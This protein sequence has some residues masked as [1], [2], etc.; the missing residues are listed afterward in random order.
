MVD[1]SLDT[2]PVAPNQESPIVTDV[3]IGV[4]AI[5]GLLPSAS[6]PLD[7]L[8]PQA[9][10]SVVTDSAL[11][12]PVNG[13]NAG[14][15]KTSGIFQSAALPTDNFEPQ[16]PESAI[17]NVVNGEVIINGVDVDAVRVSGVFPSAVLPEDNFEPQAP[18]SVLNDEFSRH[19]ETAEGEDS[20]ASGDFP[21]SGIVIATPFTT[22]EPSTTAFQ[23]K[24]RR[25]I[26]FSVGND[27]I[28][29]NETAASI[30]NSI[31]KS[32]GITLGTAAGL[33][34]VVVIAFGVALRRKH[35]SSTLRGGSSRQLLLPV[36]LQA[37]SGVIVPEVSNPLYKGRF[38][39]PAAVDFS[40]DSQSLSS[41]GFEGE[42]HIDF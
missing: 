26:P 27:F 22:L 34:V 35:A 29:A 9:P 6:I 3:T 15:V 32:I 4:T 31:S 13:G 1:T 19:N 28:Q 14:R 20:S 39:N 5:S 25:P 16:A 2:V 42:E 40:L 33:V 12:V 11:N 23:L 18:S 10:Q 30:N 7:N 8:E 21:G 36:K 17:F 38:I 24:T 41:T 37:M